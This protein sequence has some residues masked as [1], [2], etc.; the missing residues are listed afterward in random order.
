MLSARVWLRCHLSEARA[1]RRGSGRQGP[2]SRVWPPLT[3]RPGPPD[4]GGGWRG[5]GDTWRVWCAGTGRRT[6]TRRPAHTEHSHSSWSPCT[7]R[8]ETW[9]IVKIRKSKKF[10]YFKMLNLDWKNKKNII[11]ALIYIIWSTQGGPPHIF[12]LQIFKGIKPLIPF[13]S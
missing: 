1:P 3:A 5:M 6:G 12:G 4:K 13:N 8:P 10:I 11:I 7:A 2:E 9:K